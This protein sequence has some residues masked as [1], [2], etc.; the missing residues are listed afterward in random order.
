VNLA[1]SR[2]TENFGRVNSLCFDRWIFDPGML[3][4]SD[5]KW[6]GDQGLRSRRHNG[7]DLQRYASDGDAVKDLE[8]DMKVPMMFDG[9]VVR[10]IKDFLGETF[11]AVHEIF[12]GDSQLFTIFGHLQPADCFHEG[13]SL[14]EG[15]VFATVCGTGNAGVPAH[16]H[17]SAALIPREIRVESLTWKIVD[18]D[19]RIRFIDPLDIV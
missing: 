1:R 8:H 4:L 3:F 7:L 17:L 16:I 19:A 18:N 6:W 11:F 15:D 9:S 13:I 5:R 10:R 2:F 14:S 12:D